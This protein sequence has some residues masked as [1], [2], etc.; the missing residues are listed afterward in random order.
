MFSKCNKSELRGRESGGEAASA[1]PLLCCAETRDAWHA[2][3][4]HKLGVVFSIAAFIEGYCDGYDAARPDTSV[5]RSEEK[6]S[7]DDAYRLGQKDYREGREPNYARY[8]DR[9]NP[10]F[11]PFFRRGYADG[12]YSA[13]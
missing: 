2:S 13:R 4:I 3:N 5:M 8:A 9:F 7:Y 1:E 10:R 6:D 11:E 12:Y